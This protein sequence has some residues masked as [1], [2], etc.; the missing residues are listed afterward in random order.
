MLFVSRAYREIDEKSKASTA[1]SILVKR[2]LKLGF[3]LIFSTF[4]CVTHIAQSERQT[5]EVE[6]NFF[7]QKS[8]V[9]NE[10]AH[11]CYVQFCS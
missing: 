1:P 5:K 10:S 6:R 11:F 7:K 8:L 4:F 9:F 3:L 2:F